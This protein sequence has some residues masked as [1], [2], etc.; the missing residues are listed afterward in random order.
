LPKPWPNTIATSPHGARSKR[1]RIINLRRRSLRYIL[2]MNDQAPALRDG[3]INTPHIVK[4][5]GILARVVCGHFRPVICDGRKQRKDGRSL[6]SGAGVLM[7]IHGRA[8]TFRWGKKANN[9]VFA[10]C[11][12]G[13]RSWNSQRHPR[14]PSY[15]TRKS[16]RMIWTCRTGTFQSKLPKS[17]TPMVRVS[18]PFWR[19]DEGDPYRRSAYVG[20]F[21][22]TE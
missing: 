3:P 1:S 12:T 17:Q 19:W 8:S 9:T 2:E 6:G 13:K 14:R 15:Q 7:P 10:C 5:Y 11:V 22:G 4:I 18:Q 21:C 16:Q 20:A